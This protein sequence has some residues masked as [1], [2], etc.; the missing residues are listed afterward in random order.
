ME[1]LWT[2]EPVPW[3]E[4]RVEWLDEAWGLMVVL[5]T[6]FL[7]VDQREYA[8]LVDRYRDL[9]L[10]VLKDPE[11]EAYYA[12][13]FPRKA[14]EP[15]GSKTPNGQAAMPTPQWKLDHVASIQAQLM[16]DVF[17]S[18][19][20][21][22]YANAPDNRGWMNLFRRW[23]RA[24]A[25]RDRFQ[26][27]RETYSKDFVD[28][29]DYYIRDRDP[30]DLDPVPHPWDRMSRKLDPRAGPPPSEEDLEWEKR[31]R[32]HHEAPERYIPGVY[33]DSGI[34][35]AEPQK[36][37]PPDVQSGAHAADPAKSS[38][39]GSPPPEPRAGGT[40]SD[41]GGMIPQ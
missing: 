6:P 27:M 13:T 29:Y 22:R 20:L 39:P 24:G 19:R 7:P 10:L 26:V 37:Q 16:E 38:A 15:A 35:E 33:L 4:E 36:P 30:I 11:L 34:R 21:D 40:A 32:H 23:G 12:E 31:I 5:H 17:Y 2:A 25:F 3:T 8:R 41:P 1:P 18:F 28:F 9:E 14:P